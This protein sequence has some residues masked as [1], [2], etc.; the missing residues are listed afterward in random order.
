MHKYEARKFNLPDLKGISPKQ[1]EVHLKLYEG[2]VKFVNQLRE[3]LTDLRKDTEKNAYALGEVL[4]RFGFEYNGMKFHEL[5]FEGFENGPTPL[6]ENS[7]LMKS[8]VEKYGN[9]DEFWIHFKSVGLMRGI[10][11]TVLY[12]DQKEKQPHVAWVSDHELGVLADSPIILAMDMWEHAFMIDYLPSEKSKYID[13][14][15]EN[16][17]WDI[18]EKRFKNS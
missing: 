2:Y 14:F 15:K 10:G 13:A 17:N 8:L 6:N 7:S 11:W 9:F 5:Y 1:L 12:Y 18:L 16:L 3:T 4:R